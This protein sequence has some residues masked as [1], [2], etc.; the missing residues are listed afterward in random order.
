[1]FGVFVF[2]LLLW[3][4]LFRLCCF[5]VCL[6]LVVWCGLAMLGFCAGDCGCVVIVV[7][8]GMLGFWWLMWGN[9]S[10]FWVGAAV[11]GRTTC[12]AWLVV[13]PFCG[14]CSVGFGFLVVRGRFWLTG[15]PVFRGFS[16]G[17]VF[18]FD[19]WF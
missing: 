14:F 10:G 6:C 4:C 12:C 8:I 15:F 3:L 18:Y 13:V 17:L 1:M 7:F 19:R 2:W 16:L 11:V 5:A 9:S